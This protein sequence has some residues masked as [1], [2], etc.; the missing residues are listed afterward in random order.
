MVK[1]QTLL[2]LAYCLDP[3][4]VGDGVKLHEVQLLGGGVR[5]W[6]LCYVVACGK[7]AEL[8]I[9]YKMCTW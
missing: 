4:I 7:A 3:N 1:L 9:S 5:R 2:L 8:K 6:Y